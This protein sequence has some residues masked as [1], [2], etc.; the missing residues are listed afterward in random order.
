M[1]AITNAA[2]RDISAP[3]DRR[4]DAEIER[5]VAERVAEL[6]RHPIAKYVFD[7]QLWAKVAAAREAEQ[8]ER[9]EN[10]EHKTIAA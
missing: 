1:G 6:K 3:E 5:D 10:G 8:A 2:F 7:E 4:T 9:R